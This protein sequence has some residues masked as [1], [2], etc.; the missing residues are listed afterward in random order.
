MAKAKEN[1]EQRRRQQFGG[2]RATNE[3]GWPASS[4]NPVFG[5]QPA[6]DDAE[7]GRPDQDQAEATG[8]GSG[9][10]TEGSQRVV[11]HSATH[12]SNTQK[13]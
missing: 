11:R 9:G 5:G 8:A 7:A 13:Q 6:P 4:P 1:R 10:A 2:H 3:A 12:A